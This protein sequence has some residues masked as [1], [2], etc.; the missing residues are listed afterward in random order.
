MSYTALQKIHLVTHPAA[1]HW[2]V[3]D[4]ENSQVRLLFRSALPSVAEEEPAKTTRWIQ[5]QITLQIR[6]TTR[7]WRVAEN[8]SLELTSQITLQ[9]RPTT[10]GWRVA[11]NSSLELTSQITLQIRPAIRGWRVAS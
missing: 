4:K 10:R 6:P 5:S 2:R 8:S 3:A 1:R 11:E 9:I 7:G